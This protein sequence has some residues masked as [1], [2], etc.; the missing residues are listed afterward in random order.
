MANKHETFGGVD[1]AQFEFDMLIFIHMDT[2]KISY[3]DAVEAAKKEIKENR[4][5][6]LEW[7]ELQK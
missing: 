5:L 2:D 3:E 4:K 6:D 1:A 7:L